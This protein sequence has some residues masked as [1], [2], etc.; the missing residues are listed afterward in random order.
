[1]TDFDNATRA[2]LENE[3]FEQTRDY[4]RRGRP[5]AG[6]AL[7][8]LEARWVAAFRDFA[9]DIGDDVDLVRMFDLEAEHR[10]RGLGLPEELVEEEQA[11]L[12]RGMEDW[13]ENDPKSWDEMA[14]SVFEEIVD[15]HCATAVAS[16][17]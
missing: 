8:D 1:M 12:D 4:L 16:K 10:L 9:A 17:S 15:F 3:R 14:D 11:V 6:L 13:L 5:Y 7:V 2:F